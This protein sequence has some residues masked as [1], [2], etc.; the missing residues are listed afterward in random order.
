MPFPAQRGK[1][2]PQIIDKIRKRFSLI[3]RV[4]CLLTDKFKK[5]SNLQSADLRMIEEQ[6]RDGIRDLV[7]LIEKEYKVTVAEGLLEVLDQCTGNILGRIYGEAHASR[8][9]RNKVS[10]QF[11]AFIGPYM[12]GI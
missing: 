11:S 4:T 1:K 8:M 3:N 2:S 7:N 10:S 12:C 5:N 9:L 6:V